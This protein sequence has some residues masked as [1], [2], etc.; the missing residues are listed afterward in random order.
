MITNP[1]LRSLLDAARHAADV[2][3]DPAATTADR[4]RASGDLRR[5]TNIAS[6]SLN[7]RSTR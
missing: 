3:D 6:V 4:D 1:V 7:R 5:A 2:L